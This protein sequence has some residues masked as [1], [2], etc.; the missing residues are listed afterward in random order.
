[1]TNQP[2]TP[3]SES[4]LVASVDWLNGLVLGSL[5]A[6]LC[7]IA[8]AAVGLMMLGGRLP[9]RQG[10]RVI[11]GCFILLGAP[12]IAAGFMG[13]WLEISQAPVIVSQSVIIP[14]A[15]PREVAPSAPPP[16]SAF[17]PYSGASLRRD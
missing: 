10:M 5:A 6:G 14:P 3:Q 1:M 13:V 17:D 8:V 11:L 12:V 2:Y 15:A 7:V 4:A 9:L 16:A